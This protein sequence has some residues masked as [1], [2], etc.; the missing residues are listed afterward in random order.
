M[1]NNLIEHFNQFALAVNSVDKATFYNIEG[2]F[3]DLV[4]KGLGACY[5]EICIGNMN[6]TGKGVDENLQ[7]LWCSKSDEKEN[8]PTL[9]N[10]DGSYYSQ[11]SYVYFTGNSLWLAVKDKEELL[12]QID[13]EEV[14]CQWVGMEHLDIPLYRDYDAPGN[15]KSSIIVP[16]RYQNRKIGVFVVEFPKVLPFNVGARDE[17]LKLTN[18]VSTLIERKALARSNE[19]D[20]LNAFKSFREQS[21]DSLSQLILPGIKSKVFFAYP[22]ECDKDVV[23]TVLNTINDN[24]SD[25]IQLVDW[26]EDIKGGYITKKIVNSISSSKFGIC[27]LSEKSNEGELKYKDNKNVLF[28]AG[29][30]YSLVDKSMIDWLP[31]RESKELAGDPPLDFISEGMVITQRNADGELNKADLETSLTKYLE[32]AFGQ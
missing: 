23:A 11:K 8:F 27:Y 29:M 32:A 4:Q 20:T 13:P 25:R 12:N 17:L 24:F 14:E 22:K 6:Q 18:T 10:D 28:E 15:S 26:S 2:F 5:Y 1:T 7:V 21:S 31:I 30:M 19:M 16:L 3:Y 9:Y